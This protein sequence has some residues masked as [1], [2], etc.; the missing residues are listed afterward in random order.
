[1]LGDG[2]MH[3][4][5]ELARA[6]RLAEI[7]RQTVVAAVRLVTQA[8]PRMP[9]PGGSKDSWLELIEESL[10]TGANARVLT[11]CVVAWHRQYPSPEWLSEFGSPL[12]VWL[13]MVRNQNERNA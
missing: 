4:G 10:R 2:R 1:M 6:Q 13:G 7:D 5:S 9:M 11:H 3:P 12:A 8:N